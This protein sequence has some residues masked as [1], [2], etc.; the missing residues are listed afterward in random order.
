MKMAFKLYEIYC[1]RRQ[2]QDTLPSK[3][4]ENTIKDNITVT[5]SNFIQNN[6]TIRI[7]THFMAKTHSK[8]L[9]TDQNMIQ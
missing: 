4:D 7:L 2:Y 1:W 6:G 5:S 9:I 3:I 8:L